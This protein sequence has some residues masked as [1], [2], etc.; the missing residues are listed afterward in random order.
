ME[1]PQEHE[2]MQSMGEFLT[3]ATRRGD[4]ATAGLGGDG[5]IGGAGE[6]L[7]GGRSREGKEGGRGGAGMPFYRRS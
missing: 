1:E 5:E 7:E 4:G 3:G 2:M 6:L